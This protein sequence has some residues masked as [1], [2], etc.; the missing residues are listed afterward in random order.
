[1][2]RL[3]VI[4][5]IAAILV[6]GCAKTEQASD[7]TASQKTT[8]SG[9]AQQKQISGKPDISA[10]SVATSSPSFKAG[11][12][13]TIY[14]TVKNLGGA[15]TGVEVGLYANGKLIN[16]YNFDFKSEETKGPMYVWYPDNAGEY[17]IKIIV[18]PNKKLDEA[19]TANNQA[20]S[21]VEIFE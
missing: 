12:R 2:K 21:K 4:F 3:L 18:D 13:L 1:M 9:Q 17:E 10:V 6:A 8:G 20:S 5:L 15:I 11:D 14:P 16:M 19:D 7:K